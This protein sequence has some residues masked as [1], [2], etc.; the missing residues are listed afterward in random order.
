MTTSFYSATDGTATDRDA[1]IASNR[2]SSACAV[3]DSPIARAAH[4][5]GLA[6]SSAAAI[7]PRGFSSRLGIVRE[8]S[9]PDGVLFLFQ[10]Q[11]G[12]EPATSSFGKEVLN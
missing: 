12:L 8:K 9:T 7:S 1:A 10:R 5:A 6:P 11:T 4:A 3:L 2:R